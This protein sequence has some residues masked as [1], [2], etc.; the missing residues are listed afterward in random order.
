LEPERWT[1][2]ADHGER[3]SGI[4]DRLVELGLHVEVTSLPVGDFLVDHRAAI[5]RKTVQDLHRSIANARLWRQI[6]A[7]RAL[8]ATRFLLV[9]GANLWNGPVVPHGVRGALLAAS[10]SGVAVVRSTD[11]EESAQWIRAIAGRIHRPARPPRRRQ[12][13]A[14]SPYLL[15]RT[16]RGMSPDVAQLLLDTFGSIGGIASA[17]EAELREVHGVGPAKAAVLRRLLS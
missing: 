13:S 1:I 15:L 14:S 3:R 11:A 4:P 7:L 17:T 8:F 10:E 9:E 16:I 12:P 5:E 6:R 2:L